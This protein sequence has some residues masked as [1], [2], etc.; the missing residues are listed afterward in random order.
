MLTSEVIPA[1]QYNI[2]CSHSVGNF[3]SFF[4]CFQLKFLHTA[5]L[6]SGSPDTPDTEDHHTHKMMDT[7][8]VV[9]EIFPHI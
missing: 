5:P 9:L 2:I 8:E 1:T 4:E 6:K 7:F 3:S